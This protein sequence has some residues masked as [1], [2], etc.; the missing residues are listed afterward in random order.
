MFCVTFYSYKGGVG[1]TLALANVAALLARRGKRVLVV[2]FDLEAPG[3]TTIPQFCGGAKRQGIVEYVE[4]Y[5]TTGKAPDL[6]SYIHECQLSESVRSEGSSKLEK[7][8]ID[9]MPAG[10][11]DEHY[12]EKLSRI[13]WNMLYAEKQG[14]L[15]M[16]DLRARWKHAGYDYV[17]IDSRTGHTDVG[18]ICTRQLPDAVVAVFFPNEQN[19]VGLKSVVNSIRHAGARPQQI[20]LLF[21]ASR[22]PRLDDEDGHLRRWLERFQT[23]LGYN[24]SSLVRVEHYDSLSLLN[25]TLFSMERPK[26]GLSQ[27]YKMLA[28]KIS[29][30]NFEDADGALEFVTE[31]IRGNGGAN[32][33]ESDHRSFHHA[34]DSISH[35]HS[36]DCIIQFELSRLYYRKRSLVKALDSADHALRA[37]GNTRT[38]ATPKL[39]FFAGVHRQR[40]RILRELGRTSEAVESAEAI[41]GSEHVTAKIIIDAL[42]MLASSKP[43]LLDDAI[44][45]PALSSAS[46]E[47]QFEIA[48]QLSASGGSDTSSLAGDLAEK[49]I[50]GLKA[51]KSE[52]DFD[53]YDL[54]TALIA[55]GRFALAV[56]VAGEISHDST[57]LPRLF[58]TAMAAWGRDG[59]ADRNRFTH[60]WRVFGGYSNNSL[61]LNHLE[62]LALTAAVL[63]ESDIVSDALAKARESLHKSRRS[64]FSCWTFTNRSPQEFEQDLDAIEK[65]ARLG[66][67]EP[68]CIALRQR[69]HC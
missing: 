30:L 14:F 49:A 28:S 38:L 4:S 2:D 15:L 44:N 5:L 24:E 62:C 34:L 21:V 52:V 50:Q 58:N 9:V 8:R 23:E 31:H 1:R 37:L 27:Q 36:G 12:G 20:E 17:L 57:D 61:G 3:L 46:A 67:P 65:F 60:V 39:T 29:R 66:F 35:F 6:T 22:V 16:E 68:A 18:G 13:D 33:D 63:G 10:L 53:P 7:H 64:D 32:E 51:S 43:D 25:Q 69:G 48:E 59:V 26:S 47:D 19:L 55:A 40:L 41:L 54:Q 11:D 45:S 42:F 56:E